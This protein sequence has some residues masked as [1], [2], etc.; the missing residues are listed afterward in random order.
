MKPTRAEFAALVAVLTFTVAIPFLYALYP[1]VYPIDYRVYMNTATG[2]GDFYYP[3]WT[4]FILYP[5]SLLPFWIGF[6]VW[7]ALNIGCIYAACKLW[8]GNATIA[9]LSYPMLFAAFY[10]QIT[11]LLVLAL[12]LYDRWIADKPYLAGIA[13]AIA[14]TK[15]QLAVPVL[16][17]SALRSNVTWHNRLVSVLPTLALLALSLLVYGDWITTWLVHLPTVA[18]EGSITMWAI[19][20]E[21]ALLLWLPLGFIAPDK[22]RLFVICTTALSLPYFQLTGLLLLLAAL[23][24]SPFSALAFIGYGML[25]LGWFGASLMLLLPLSV[26]IW[27]VLVHAKTQ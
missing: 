21:W 15:P 16:L 6:V 20:G 8:D 23:P 12:V 24:L 22:R 5:F 17:Y 11:G 3:Y 10:G 4:L 14:L 7:N 26:Y 13:A 25:T 19:L 2:Q 18:T 27:I 1:E 9:L